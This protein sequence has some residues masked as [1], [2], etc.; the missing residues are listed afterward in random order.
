MTFTRYFYAKKARSE[1]SGLYC[2]QRF[3]TCLEKAQ[4]LGLV[5]HF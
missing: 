1:F 2:L 5:N 4:K 3:E